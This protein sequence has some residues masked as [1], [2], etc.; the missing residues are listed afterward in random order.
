MGLLG[1]FRLIKLLSD[2]YFSLGSCSTK[3]SR[4][5]LVEKSLMGILHMK[6]FKRLVR[7]LNHGQQRPGKVQSTEPQLTVQGCNCRPIQPFCRAQLYESHHLLAPKEHFCPLQPTRQR[8]IRRHELPVALHFLS[9]YILLV[10]QEH[11][12]VLSLSFNKTSFTLSAS[13]TLLDKSAALETSIKCTGCF[14]CIPQI[15]QGVSGRN[16]YVFYMS[17]GYITAYLCLIMENNLP[18]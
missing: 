18:M 15:L 11:H 5:S 14:L 13:A 1:V 17:A 2:F 16:E 6:N 7:G 12:T 10:H 8:K 3:R 4:S 9:K